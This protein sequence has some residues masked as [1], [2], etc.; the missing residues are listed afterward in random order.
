MKHTTGEECNKGQLS[1]RIS[2]G[3]T[4]S[5][6]QNFCKVVKC[7]KSCKSSMISYDFVQSRWVWNQCIASSK[8]F[9][10][11]WSLQSKL[12]SI[13]LFAKGT[14]SWK[15]CHQ[16]VAGSEVGFCTRL[17]VRKMSMFGC[18]RLK[19]Y[20]TALLNIS[21]RLTSL[22]DVVSAKSVRSRSNAEQIPDS[23]LGLLHQNSTTM[24]NH[25][26]VKF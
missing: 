5:D 2:W 20:E 22:S 11:L 3:A 26:M 8:P 21:G 1:L 9:S 15:L 6:C 18:V 14:W 19:I 16:M 17:C 4:S 10:D 25:N 13:P 24:S 12:C 7:C 23:Q